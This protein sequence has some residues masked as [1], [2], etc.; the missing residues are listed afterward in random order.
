MCT[1]YIGTSLTCGFNHFQYTVQGVRIFR[2]LLALQ[3]TRQKKLKKQNK[4]VAHLAMRLLQGE[5]GGLFS[6]GFLSIIYTLPLLP[7]MREK[8]SA[9]DFGL[10]CHCRL[11]AGHW[12]CILQQDYKHL[13]LMAGHTYCMKAIDSCGNIQLTLKQSKWITATK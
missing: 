5:S 4:D 3:N 12:G 2:L 9:L 6:I 7:I 11:R 10:T 13:I 1:T 8:S